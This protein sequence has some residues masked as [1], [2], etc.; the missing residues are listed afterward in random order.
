MFKFSN[1][2]FR[3][4]YSVCVNAAF[5]TGLVSVFSWCLQW[6]HVGC[7][8]KIKAPAAIKCD[9]ARAFPIEF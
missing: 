3:A 7:A 1:K 9:K 6:D 5:S 2:M 8:H 4:L